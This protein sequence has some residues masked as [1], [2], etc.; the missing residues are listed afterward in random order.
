MLRFKEGDRAR[1][2]DRALTPTDAKTGLYYNYYRHLTGT[3][4]KIYGS[5]PDAQA[6]L[7]VDLDSLPEDVARRHLDVRDQMRAALTGEARRLSAPGAEQE[8]R[9]RYVVLVA[10]ADLARP[11]AS[12]TRSANG[13]GSTRLLE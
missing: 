7:D 1:I 11:L 10:L 8:F 4:F 12:R 3:V 2:V 6:A 9:L 5:G 13:N